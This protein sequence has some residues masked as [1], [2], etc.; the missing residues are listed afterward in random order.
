MGGCNLQVNGIAG[1]WLRESKQHFGSQYKSKVEERVRQVPS[2]KKVANLSIP[3]RLNLHTLRTYAR[4][5][6]TWYAYYVALLWS[7]T[8]Q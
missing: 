4:I 1:C 7:K 3:P 6:G 2:G 8:K 5:L